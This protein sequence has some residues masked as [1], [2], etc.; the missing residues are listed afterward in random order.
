MPARKETVAKN[1]RHH[2]STEVGLPDLL[3]GWK[4]IADLL[5]QSVSI[6]QRWAG[7]GMPVRREG[8]SV[9]A[10]ASELTAWL[11]RESG[12]PVRLST[13]GDDLAAEL[14]R[15]LAYVQKRK[16]R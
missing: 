5:G 3:K 13:N 1:D 15:G 6:A 8:R 4:Q 7:T 12:E 9:T 16:K 10:L 11:G 2:S 14:K